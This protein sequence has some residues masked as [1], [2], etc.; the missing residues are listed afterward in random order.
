MAARAGILDDVAGNVEVHVGSRG[1]RRHFPKVEEAVAAVGK[2]D[3]HE[4]TAAEVAGGRID[5]GQRVAHR[6]GGVDGVTAL[7]ED[8]HAHLRCQV[9]GADHHAMFRAD[10]DNGRR[11]SGE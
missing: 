4:A 7:P 2:V 11:I 5:H 1:Q 8:V 9:L 10:R 3:G 6:H